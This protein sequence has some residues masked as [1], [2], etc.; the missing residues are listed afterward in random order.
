MAAIPSSLMLGVT[1]Y[2][3]TD[4]A[5]TPFLWVLPLALY[6]ASFVFAFQDKPRIGPALT[7]TLQGAAV[8]ICAALWLVVFVLKRGPRG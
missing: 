4:I 5:S 2:I 3:T 6:L 8:A 7:L 1:T